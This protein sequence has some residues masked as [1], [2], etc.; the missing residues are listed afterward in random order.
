MEWLSK[1]LDFVAKYFWALFVVAAFILVIPED[2]AKQIGLAELRETHK[3]Y[4]WVGLV[5]FGALWAGAIFKWADTKLSAWL[6]SRSD[7]KAREEKKKEHRELIEK[8]LQSLDE[9]ELL[10]LQYCLFHNTQTLSAQRGDRV[11][12]SLT[13]KGILVEGSG[14]ILDLPFHI[15]DD[16][17]RFLQDHHDEFLPQE[18]SSDPRFTH[19][20]E[21]FRKG[22]HAF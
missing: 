22:R 15:R 9:K 5:F 11:A 20:L 7:V 3:G 12:Q 8:R 10:W 19:V 2:A 4:L 17:W 6:K 13:Y 1:L 21:Q 16:V 18:A 14:H